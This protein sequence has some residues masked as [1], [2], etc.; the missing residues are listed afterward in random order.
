L[1]STATSSSSSTRASCSSA[2]EFL[3][4]DHTPAL[5]EHIDRKD[6]LM[7]PSCSRIKLLLTGS[8][9]VSTVVLT[10]LAS[11]SQQA[12][13]T[14]HQGPAAPAVAPAG[15]AAPSVAPPAAPATPSTRPAVAPG[16]RPQINLAICLDTSGS[17]DGLIEAAKQKLWAIVND[18]ALAEPTPELRI[19]LLT[20]GNNGHQAENGWV[21]IVS[22]LTEDLDLISSKLFPLST[23][24][25]EE[26]VGRVVHSA[27][28]SLSW[29]PSDNV[30]KLIIVAGNESADQD[31]QVSYKIACRESIEK[32]IM[33]NAIYCGNPADDIAPG[34]RDVALL[35]DGQFASIDHNNGTVTVSTPFDTEIAELSTAV[36]ATYIPYGAKGEWASQNQ[37]EQ[38]GNASNLGAEAAAQRAVTKGCQ[39]LYDNRSWDLVDACREQTVKLEEIKD[40]DLP[41]AMKGMNLDQRRSYVAQMQRE[42]EEIQGKLTELGQKRQSFAEEEMRKLQL[43]DSKAFDRVIRDAIRAQAAR[44]GLKFAEPAP[45][46]PVAEGAAAPA[47]AAPAA[48]ATAPAGG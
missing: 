14:V 33:V 26:Y 16:T 11:A 27:A 12:R 24:G 29:N 34:W 22:D 40:E 21:E 30:L 31:Q 6:H 42:R 18:L 3:R 36:N 20:Y 1:L 7:S 4:R 32:G 41:E 28:K 48:P 46:A 10:G 45:Q 13:Q 19:A 47:A 37:R 44:C 35:A 25:G 8:A 38:D 43:D 2:I 5:N 39:T 15:A 9:F 23:N 17:M